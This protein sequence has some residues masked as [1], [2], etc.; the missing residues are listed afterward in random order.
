MLI[1]ILVVCSTIP[2][3]SGMFLLFY[4]LQIQHSDDDPKYDNIQ[5]DLTAIVR[6]HR[7]LTPSNRDYSLFHHFYV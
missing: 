7:D 3:K 5:P 2:K 6:H 4:I 1:G